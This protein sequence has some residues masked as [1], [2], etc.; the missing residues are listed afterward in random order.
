MA[1]AS[2]VVFAIL[3]AGA[4]VF[5][6]YAT[7]SGIFSQS[8]L[9]LA[10]THFNLVMLVANTGLNLVLAPLYGV[11]GAAVATSLSF[12]AGTLFFRRGVRHHLAVRF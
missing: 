3:M 4:C 10:Q 2:W 7:F 8:G 5:G 6:A 9:P 12:I 11:H 1:Q